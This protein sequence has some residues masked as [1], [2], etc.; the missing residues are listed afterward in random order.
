MTGSLGRSLA[1]F[2]RRCHSHSYSLACTTPQWLLHGV[3]TETDDS[4]QSGQFDGSVERKIIAGSF[5]RG[6]TAYLAP[7]QCTPL[8]RPSALPPT[9]LPDQ[10]MHFWR[11]SERIASLHIMCNAHCACLIACQIFFIQNL[12]G[13][14]DASHPPHGCIEIRFEVTSLISYLAILLSQV[15]SMLRELPCPSHIFSKAICH[16]SAS[17]TRTNLKRPFFLSCPQFVQLLL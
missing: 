13:E 2:S 6:V 14:R 16:V 1:V 10:V 11:I 9:N 17:C 5:K 4:F 3:D 8:G 12:T 7:G 15:L